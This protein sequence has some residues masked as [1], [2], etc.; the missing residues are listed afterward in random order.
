MR[1]DMTL[2][3]TTALWNFTFLRSSSFITEIEKT[4]TSGS[5]LWFSL[6]TFY[7]LFFRKKLSIN[8]ATSK[9]ASLT[10]VGRWSL[11][12][13]PSQRII[14][15]SINFV[16]FALVF[17]HFRRIQKWLQGIQGPW[18]S[19]RKFSIKINFTLKPPI[20]RSPYLSIAIACMHAQGLRRD[21]IRDFALVHILS[22][23]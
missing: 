17:W 18:G 3:K 15:R 1:H 14:E 12:H 6:W 2:N 9:N 23:W 8:L 21:K 10:S 19:F 20:P 4:Q 5:W 13:V 16:A 7:M 22:E 11:D